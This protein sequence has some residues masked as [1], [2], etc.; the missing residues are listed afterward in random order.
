MEKQN[1]FL[2]FELLLA[3]LFIVA[4]FLPWLDWGILK[5]IGWDIPELQKKMTKVTNFFKFFSKNKEWIYSTHVVYVIPLLS[6]FVMILWMML[7]KKTSRILLMIT[8]VFGLIVSLNL[9]YKLPKAGSGVYLLTASSVISIVY[10]I[11]IFCRK[12]KVEPGSE[13]IETP[14]EGI[15]TDVK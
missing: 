7:K 12:K 14:P 4:F 13:L 2:S 11:I 1:R 5:V 8:G 3:I 9:F 15:D 10:L 6:I